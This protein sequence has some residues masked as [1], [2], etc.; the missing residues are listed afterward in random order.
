PRAQPGRERLAVHARQLALQPHLQ[1]LRRSRRPLLCGMEQARRSA[2]AHHVHRTAPMGPR[3]LINGIWYKY[4]SPARRAATN[5]GS[6][7]AALVPK[8]IFPTLPGGIPARLYVESTVR[9]K[10][11]LYVPSVTPK[12]EG[13]PGN[14]GIVV[15]TGTLTPV[16]NGEARQQ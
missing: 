12:P 4:V 11:W 16:W 14:E 8:N 10:R 1:I 13:K 6:A 2:L 15:A 3:V 5:T 7:V 9:S